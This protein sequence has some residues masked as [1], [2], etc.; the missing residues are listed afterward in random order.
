MPRSSRENREHF[1]DFYLPPTVRGQRIRP[2]V[3][4]AFEELWP[5][6]WAFVGKQLGDAA[7]AADLAEEIAARVSRNL[8]T[9]QGEIRSLI[10]FCRVSAVNF[11]STT[12]AREGR[13]DYRGLGQDIET[14]LGPAAPNEHEDAELAIWA[15]QILEGHNPDTRTMLQLRLLDRTWPQIGSVLGITGDQAR[16]RFR[17]AMEETDGHA[18]PPRPKRERS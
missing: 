15:D 13:I 17:R 14:T 18:L 11:I 6:F 10:A 12:K 5:W 9:H 3:R 4:T 8:E 1:P 7:R 16:L 2:E